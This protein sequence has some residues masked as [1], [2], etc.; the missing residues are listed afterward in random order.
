MEENKNEIT[1]SDEVTNP[2]F[3][4]VYNAVEELQ[5]ES[6]KN[7]NLVIKYFILTSIVYLPIILFLIYALIQVIMAPTCTGISY[8]F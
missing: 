5:K 4:D 7:L 6:K 1:N 3:N 2:T 8:G